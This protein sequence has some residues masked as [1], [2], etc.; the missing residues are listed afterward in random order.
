MVQ[1]DQPFSVKLLNK[2]VMK[3]VLLRLCHSQLC[4]T[5]IFLLLLQTSIS[6]SQNIRYVDASIAAGGNGQ[7]WGSAY[8]TL[9]E[10]LDE[11]NATPAIGEIRVARGTYYPTGVQSGN[12]RNA[13]FGIFRGGLKILGGFP[14]GGSGLR[15]LTA[16]P[17]ILSGAIDKT[18]DDDNSRHVMVISG[19]PDEADSVVVDG[20]QIQQATATG[21]STASYNG[22]SLENGRGGGIAIL[23][24]PT[25]VVGYEARKIIRISRCIIRGN[26][27]SN[28]GAGVY[29]LRASPLLINCVISGNYADYGGGMMNLAGAWPFILNCTIAGNHSNN[30]GGGGIRNSG[31]GT[32]P[33][34]SGSIVYGNSGGGI[35][36]TDGANYDLYYSLVQGVV[37]TPNNNL[38]G[39]DIANDPLFVA[40]AAAGR[41]LDGD[42]R[43]QSGSPCID[44]GHIDLTQY[45]HPDLAGNVRRV[46][47]ADM[48]AFEFPKSTVIKTGPVNRTICAGNGTSVTV[49]AE[50]AT[51]YEWQV[52]IGSADFVTVQDGGVYNGATTATLALSNATA[53]MNGYRF[54]CVVGGE[55]E[56][57]ATSGTATLTV[58]TPPI[59][60]Q[61]PVSITMCPNGSGQLKVTSPNATSYRWEANIDGSGF[62]YIGTNLTSMK[63]TTTAT[64]TIDSPDSYME[65]WQFRCALTSACSPVRYTNVVKFNF[66]P[67]PIVSNPIGNPE[68]CVGS[69]QSYSVTASNAASYQWQQFRQDVNGWENL[70][71][72]APHSGTMS[73]TLT[74]ASVDAGLNGRR[75]R[76]EVTNDCQRRTASGV[77]QMAVKNPVVITRNPIGR[78]ECLGYTARFNV[79]ATDA[80]GF[81]WQ[82]RIPN[83]TFADLSDGQGYTGTNSSQLVIQPITLAMNG[84]EYRCVVTN[85]CASVE[86]VSSAALLEVFEDLP[87]ITV[88]PENFRACMGYGAAF[89]L[90]ASS[91]WDYRWQVN[92]GNGFVDL[93]NTFPFSN[94]STRTLNVAAV[95]Q[96]IMHY[97][98]RCVVSGCAGDVFSSQAGFSQGHEIRYVKEGAQGAGTSW[99]DASGDLQ[100]TMNEIFECGE[101]WVA[102]GTYKPNRPATNIQVIDANNRNNSFVLTRNVKLYGGFPG[103]GAPDMDQRDWNQHLT[104][105]SGDVGIPDLQDD[106]VFHVL[107]SDGDVGRAELNGFVVT[108]G[109]AFPNSYGAVQGAYSGY[110]GGGLLLELSSPTI[111]NCRFIDNHSGSAGGAIATF[112]SSPVITNCQFVSNLSGGAG[113]SR[114]G[115]ISFEWGSPMISGSLFAGNVASFG[116][117]IYSNARTTVSNSLFSG[118]RGE[119]DGGAIS[120]TSAVANTAFD[121]NLTN[122]TIAGNSSPQGNAINSKSLVTMKNC[123]V[124]GPANSNISFDYSGGFGQGLNASYS[125]FPSTRSGVG[126]L[127]GD[128]L[129]VNS[130]PFS[131]SP[132]TTGDYSLQPCSPAVN[133]GDQSTTG[134]IDVAGLPRVQLGRADIGAYEMNGYANGQAQIVSSGSQSATAYQLASGTT[135]YAANCNTLLLSVTGSGDHPLAGISHAKTWIGAIEG[136]VQRHYEIAPENNATTATGRITLYFT[137]ADFDAYNKPDKPMLP[138]DGDDVSGIANLR[139]QKRS[140]TS[141]DNSGL[142]ASYDPGTITDINPADTDIVWN[143]PQSRWEVT[144]DVTGF[145]GFFAYAVANNPLPVTLVSFIA[146]AKEQSVLLTWKTTSEINASHFEIERSGNGKTWEMLGT[147]SANGASAGNYDY[148]DAS[149][150]RSVNYYRLKMVDRATDRLDGSYSYSRIVSVDHGKNASPMQVS[151]YPNPVSSGRLTV[152]TSGAGTPDV[153]VYN[154]LGR[155]V[156]VHILNK[157]IEGEMDL[158]VSRLPAGVYLISVRKKEEEQ[159]LRFVVH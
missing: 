61:Q 143:A 51:R 81:K 91:T 140:G 135:W 98:F 115:A 36:N 142:P 29:I 77:L 46:C 74:I 71:E 106:N 56:P 12:D 27:A 156:N 159:L 137:Q 134:G 122:V 17:T 147:V 60:S 48:G 1:H 6:Y 131:N 33:R 150:L 19:I 13:T 20:F 49:A 25:S 153:T 138:K 90:T 15:D 96:E 31:S 120:H 42:Y 125:M 141:T 149:P 145:S 119:I 64:L 154:L 39:T 23:G 9:K 88:S 7:S 128:P 157:G 107:I 85:V 111:A 78:T 124:W 58:N 52:K 66:K 73:S 55:C 59:I 116:G 155:K 69:T 26:W 151:V 110:R 89:S 10:A 113:A 4:T 2:P 86:K 18:T 75:Y 8:Q 146:K 83:G 16:N 40:T 76:C 45:S 87:Q 5:L 132:F 148:M 65:N 79:E 139:I 158:D 44:K 34:V 3:K 144:F 127:S 28:I 21:G 68:V 11:A 130:P 94:V 47:A 103:I 92:T 105:L 80:S 126:N 121:L 102:E 133:A 108:K 63:G 104:I 35:V 62:F 41:S 72:T 57:E 22:I 24:G 112:S 70:V 38:D 99:A 100:K 53:S 136:F 84:N 114:G 129:F 50:Y 152:T 118:N 67:A 43:L 30:S 93:T 54:R 37:N 123:I 117:A 82:M 32:K 95:T 101:I 97:Q 14:G 109:K